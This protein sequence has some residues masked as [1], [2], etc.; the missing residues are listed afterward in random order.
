MWFYIR[1]SRFAVAVVLEICG[2]AARYNCKSIS[3]DLYLCVCGLELGVILWKSPPGDTRSKLRQHFGAKTDCWHDFTSL[4]ARI[5]CSSPCCFAPI[6]LRNKRF[7][8]FILMVIV[9][10]NCIPILHSVGQKF[11]FLEIFSFQPWL[12]FYHYC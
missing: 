8:I 6:I 1:V 3:Y 12:Q 4:S 2:V 9:I 11:W 7:R 10:S 5:F